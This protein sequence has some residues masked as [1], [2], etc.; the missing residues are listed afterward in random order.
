METPAAPTARP[1]ILASDHVEDLLPFLAESVC[2][3]DRTGH[4]KARLGPP[5]GILALGETIG[6]NVF[7]NLH[8]DD[9]PLAIQVSESVVQ[10]EPGWSG[11]SILRLEHGDGGYR[12]FQVRVVNRLADPRLEGVVVAIRETVPDGATD[13][14]AFGAPV[15][16]SMA[17]TLPTPYLVIG[18]LGNVRYTNDAAAALLETSAAD[19][20]GRPLVELVEDEDRAS[21]RAAVEDVTARPGQRTTV[22][23][24]TADHGSRLLEI[25]LHATGT[26]DR[27][28]LVAVA[29]VDRTREP[30]LI[31][32][33]THDPLTGLA[34]RTKLSTTIT[35]LLLEMG[36][37]VSV[38]YV[39]LDHF[40]HLNDTRGHAFGDQVL[41]A[42]AE[43]LLARSRPDDLVA[44]MS[45]DEFVVVCPRT[46]AEELASLVA[47]LG[48][49]IWVDHE[50]GLQVSLSV[51]AASARPGDT[52]EDLVARADA[53]MFTA[54]RAGRS[55]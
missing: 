27:S 7:A 19:L 8:P 37:E 17:D 2:L 30:E 20:Y 22:A 13:L 42:V 50:V 29:L 15:P 46:T 45:G 35:G 14:G 21:L 25:N 33:A 51:G 40:K 49:P 52:A 5:D 28:T 44:R 48:Q 6:A 43:R 41:V 10:S 18:N 32:A 54:K 4:L 12:P 23:C 26:G 47:E 36:S 31:R 24:T 34:N 39:D 9:L 11:S 16:R 3:Y 53:A 1:G 55:A 38:A